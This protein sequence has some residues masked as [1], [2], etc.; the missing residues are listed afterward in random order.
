MQ[1][2]NIL[3]HRAASY[4][5]AWVSIFSLLLLLLGDHRVLLSHPASLPTAV[6]PG[7]LVFLLPGLRDAIWYTYFVVLTLLLLD[8]IY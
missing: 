7:A 6:A 5:T 3:C 8:M 1:A 2:L 4:R